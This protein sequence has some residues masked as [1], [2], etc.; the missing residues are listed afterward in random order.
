MGKL[1]IIGIGTKK[2]NDIS[3]EGYISI[4]KNN[5]KYLRTNHHPFSEYLEEKGVEFETFDSYFIENTSLDDVYENIINTIN[6][7]IIEYEEVNYYVPGSPYYG[8]VV[9][10]YY[11]NNT[12]EDIKVKIIDSVS[13]FQKALSMVNGNNE[14]LKVLSSERYDF[15]DI[16]INSDLLFTQIYNKDLAEKIK[17]DLGEIYGDDYKVNIIDVILDKTLEMSVFE[18]DKLK[19]YSFSTYIFVQSIEKST[20]EL[21]NVNNLL[22]LMEIL[23]GPDGCPWDRKQTHD[24]IR[25]CLIEEAYEVVDAIDNKDY[26]NFIEELGDLLLQV[27]FHGQIAKEEGY[28]NIYDIYNAICK[29]LINRHPHV[30][31]ETKAGNEGEALKSW[32]NIKSKEKLIESHSERL[33]DVPKALSPLSKSYKIQK[34]AADVGFDWPDVS[35]AVSKIHEELDELLA[36]YEK[37]DK[38]KI[39][40]ELGDLLFA[41]VNFARFLKINPDIAL[42]KTVNKFIER[43]NYIEINSSKP[44]ESMSLKE[45]DELWEESKRQ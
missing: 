13:F 35:G 22:K 17:I 21:Y 19:K 40:N 20:K 5:L 41:I 10:E 37:L 31:G 45:M 3:Y 18:L 43:F 29:K 44:L 15:Y 14:N 26:D 23:R 11:L 27:V 32:E 6:N 7:K 42:N 2:I 8:D 24:S 33:R 39:E 38:N 28:F 1:N 4:E 34:L 9:T 12:I 25:Q 16:D 36:E 30:F